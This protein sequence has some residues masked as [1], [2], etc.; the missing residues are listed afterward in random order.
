MPGLIRGVKVTQCNPVVLTLPYCIRDPGAS[1]VLQDG[2]SK[3]GMSAGL[4]MC[5]MTELGPEGAD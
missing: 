3:H 2:S 1:G 4:L 5:F